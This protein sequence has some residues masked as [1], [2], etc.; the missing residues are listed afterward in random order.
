[1][2]KKYFLGKRKPTVNDSDGNTEKIRRPKEVMTIS[3]KLEVLNEILKWN[4]EFGSNLNQQ[5][6]QINPLY[7]LQINN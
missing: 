5:C 2:I 4:I 1:M 3:Q 7:A 6:E